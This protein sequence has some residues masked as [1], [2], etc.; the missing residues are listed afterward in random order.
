MTGTSF[1]TMVRS[2]THKLVHFSD[3]DEGQLFDLTSE[4]GETRNLWNDAFAS[5]TKQDLLNRMLKFHIES[6]VHTCNARRLIVSPA[7]A[8]A[9]Q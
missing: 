3:S 7:G 1:L 5:E 9:L 4:A 2:R 8:E 6:A